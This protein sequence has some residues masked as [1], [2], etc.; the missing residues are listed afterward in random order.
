MSTK[1]NTKK[2]LLYLRLPNWLGDVCMCL[3]IIE[4][5]LK[6]NEYN[7]VICARPWAKQLLKHYPIE[8]WVFLKG[9]ML[10]DAKAVKQHR[11]Q[12]AQY[13]AKGLIIPDSFSS[14]FIFWWAK[15]P[16]A[17]VKDEGRSLMLT[18]ALNKPSHSLHTVVYWYQVAFKALNEWGT[19]IESNIPEKLSLRL[20]ETSHAQNTNLNTTL[21]INTAN[22]QNQ[23]QKTVLIAP[24]ATG[25]HKGQ[26]KVWPCFEQLTQKL[27]QK[28]C[29]VIMCPP[30]NEIKQAKNNAPS[31]ERLEPMNIDRFALLCRSVDIVVCNDS[32]VSHIAAAAHAQQITLFGVTS[33]K[34]TGPWSPYAHCL[35]SEKQWPNLQEVLKVCLKVLQLEN[36]HESI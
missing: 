31:A 13:K 32:G 18:W 3:P 15:I 16:S 14:A 4:A 17:G 25:K 8:Q 10:T 9:A 1:L 30:S 5:L 12:H 35:G 6:K 22:N 33:P 27:Q 36:V 24:T 23:L 26:T 20:P 7:L 28:G 11:R 2:T 34:L 21:K 19:P 29:R